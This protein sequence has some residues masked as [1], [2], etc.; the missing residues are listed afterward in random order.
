MQ[1]R[2]GPYIPNERERLERERLEN[3]MNFLGLVPQRTQGVLDPGGFASPTTAQNAFPFQ[4]SNRNK[5]GSW[6]A[7]LADRDNIKGTSV[8]PYEPMWPRWK[9]TPP[10]HAD[11]DFTSD[12]PF[13]DIDEISGKAEFYPPGKPLRDWNLNGN[14][15]RRQRT[16]DL[17]AGNSWRRR[18]LVGRGEDVLTD[19]SRG[20]GSTTI[21]GPAQE[22][23]G[24]A[25]TQL[26][27]YVPKQPQYP[28]LSDAQR[29]AYARR[30]AQG[31]D[32][33]GLALSI[34]APTLGRAHPA[35]GLGL[36]TGSRAL[37]N[38]EVQRAIGE[39]T[40]TKA[41]HDARKRVNDAISGILWQ[42][43]YKSG[44]LR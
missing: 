21:P 33:L 13:Y 26:A 36:G 28:I 44:G 29:E 37:S 10:P 27:F 16:G 12:E 9:Q 15:A 32:N 19:T 40:T 5:D 42:E 35:L 22:G 20:P 7:P 43:F 34:L 8:D 17:P 23:D 2:F 39:G 25:P 11:G 31:A 4:Q 24:D 14:P 6:E 30:A 18:L 3:L 38:P 41:E 1:N